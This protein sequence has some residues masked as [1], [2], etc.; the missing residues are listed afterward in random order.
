MKKVDQLLTIKW[1]SIE[2]CHFSTSSDW[3]AIDQD[4]PSRYDGGL[5]N[6]KIKKESKK[7]KKKLKK[8]IK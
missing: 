2:D 5:Q 6:L 3:S 8:T 4:L 7:F 1:S